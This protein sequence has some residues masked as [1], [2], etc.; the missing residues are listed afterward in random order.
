M[1]ASVPSAAGARRTRG[2]ALARQLRLLRQSTEYEL[3]KV[4]AFRMGFVVRELMRGVTRPLAMIY[5]YHAIY[6]WRGLGEGGLIRG[7]SYPE[8]VRYM[9]LVATFEKLIYHNRVLRVSEQIFEG[10]FTKFLVLPV[11]FF[12]LALGSFVQYAGVQ[13][14]FASLLWVLG[15]LVAPGWW[16][17]PASAVAL[18]Q[19]VS[20]V[21]LG[22]YCFFLLYLTINGLAFYL[23]VVWSLLVMAFFITSFLSGVHMPVDWMPG[24]VADALRWTFPYWTLSGPIELFLGRLGGADYLQGLGVLLGSA[25]LLD[26]LRAFVWLHGSRRYTGSGM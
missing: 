15:W 2:Q 24:P 23:E 14:G 26:R 4:L 3:R 11:R 6:Q 5:V 22:S 25:F 17:E 16:P 21:L 8:M 19:S 13:L 9:I 12:V 20:L 7:W 18:L 1:S 10:Y